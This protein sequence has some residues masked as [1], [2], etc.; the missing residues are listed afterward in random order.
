MKK[1]IL[2][3]LLALS[4]TAFSQ[5]DPDA[6]LLL[7]KA[8]SVDRIATTPVE[9]TL[10]YDT[11]DETIYYYNG[12]STWVPIT[13]RAPRVFYPPSVEVEITATSTA[14]TMNLY[15]LY[16]SEFSSPVAQSDATKTIPT[17]T[18]DQLDF[19][20]T[21][22]DVDIFANITIDATCLMTYDIIDIPD[23]DNTILNIVFVVK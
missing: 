20:V 14:N 7:T 12:S 23:D 21:K 15:N 19:Y 3:L 16:L 1:V 18:A 22:A 10:I 5:V 8:D 11:D 17:Y 2:T 6:L 9:G 13:S 4:Y